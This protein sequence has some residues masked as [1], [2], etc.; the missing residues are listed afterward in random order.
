MELYNI[1][2]LHICRFIVCCNHF[3]NFAAVGIIAS[4]V[5]SLLEKF[6]GNFNNNVFS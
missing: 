3:E 6:E 1:I 4:D 2:I 5:N